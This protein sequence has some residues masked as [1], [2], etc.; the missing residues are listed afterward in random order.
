MPQPLAPEPFRNSSEYIIQLYVAACRIDGER[1][2]SSLMSLL[3][4]RDTLA[5]SIK[6][7]LHHFKQ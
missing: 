7:V 1:F 2:A 3:Q 5:E 6:S 4:S